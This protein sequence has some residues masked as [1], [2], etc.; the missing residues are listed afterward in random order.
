MELCACWNRIRQ[1]AVLTAILMGVS[2][3]S[4]AQ[5]AVA[6]PPL[7]STELP[8]LGDLPARFSVGSALPALRRSE[9]TR[10]FVAGHLV[11]G[12]VR[13]LDRET[14]FHRTFTDVHELQGHALF[15]Y[16]VDRTERRVGRGALRAAKLYMLERTGLESAIDGWLNRRG[17]GSVADLGDASGASRDTSYGVG[18][19]GGLPEASVTRRLEK[20]Q[21]RLLLG[22]RGRS[23]V[24]YRHQRFEGVRLRLHHDIEE[25]HTGLDLRIFF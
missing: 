6:E 1:V 12:L 8:S 18:I 13:S 25:Q 20:S 24:E 22:V 2:A 17:R 16:Y 4:I 5:D 3:P 15:E 23:S 7:Q 11:P 21:V 19:S 9:Q 14:S 10:G